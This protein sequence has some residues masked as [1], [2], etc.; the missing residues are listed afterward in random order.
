MLSGHI[1]KV[2]CLELS[3]DKLRLF[4][5]SDDMTVRVWDLNSGD[6]LIS[7]KLNAPIY[8]IKLMWS[9]LLACGPSGEENLMQIIDLDTNKIAKKLEITG[10]VNAVEFDKEEA[11]LYTASQDCT[12]KIW[13]F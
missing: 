2:W 6:C 9:N 13:Q 12:V 1:S 11:V 8:C 7:V 5:G 10:S 4:S 3:F